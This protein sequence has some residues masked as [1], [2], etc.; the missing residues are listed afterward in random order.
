MKRLIITICLLC[1]GCSTLDSRMSSYIGMPKDVL[2][3]E[4]GAPDSH[5]IVNNVTEVMTW[6][7]Y[8]SNG[9]KCRKSFT[10]TGGLVEKYS[11]SKCSVF[12]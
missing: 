1:A 2:L 9:K 5:T 10:I 8:R 11:Y 6:S 7:H 12:E 4:W 3:S